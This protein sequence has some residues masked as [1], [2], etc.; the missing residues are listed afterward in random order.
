MPL[1]TPRR[2]SFPSPLD[3]PA[4]VLL[5]LL[6]VV[7]CVPPSAPLEPVWDTAAG[8]GYAACAAL[9]VA[10]RLAPAVAVDRFP[11]HRLAGHAAVV[12]V[13]AHVAVMLA[14][15]PMLLDYLGWL[16]PGY[17]LLGVVA[18]LVLPLAATGLEPAVP[19]PLRLGGRRWHAWL[20]IAAATLTAAHV[21]AA[22]LK[23]I[24]AWRLAFLGAVLL[25]PLVVPLARGV[26]G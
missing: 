23:P 3:A 2:R 15:E 25:L 26:A 21:L 17:V 1:P 14:G 11:L 18:A 10:V 16:M 12:L 7:V 9:I 5:G 13:A 4:L 19:Q 8:L 24:G 6:L 20:G 22:A